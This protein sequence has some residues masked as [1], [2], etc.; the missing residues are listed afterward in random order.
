MNAILLKKFNFFLAAIAN[1]MMKQH[2]GDILIDHQAMVQR[3]EETGEI[4]LYVAAQ[5]F[6]TEIRFQYPFNDGTP[7]TIAEA[8]QNARELQWGEYNIL[9]K[10]DGDKLLAWVDKRPNSELRFPIEDMENYVEFVKYDII[11]QYGKEKK[12]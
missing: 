9:I 7:R 12:K 2:Q 5:H 10:V 11:D 8:R 3:I 6:D 1:R 4:E